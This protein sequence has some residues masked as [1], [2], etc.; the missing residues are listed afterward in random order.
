[1]I[2]FEKTAYGWKAYAK[3]WTGAY[4]YFGHF[5]TQRDARQA[6]KEGVTA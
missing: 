1:M 5:Q 3:H 6:Y 4:V 2:Q